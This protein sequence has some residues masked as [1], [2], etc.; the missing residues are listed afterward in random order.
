MFIFG[1][2]FSEMPLNQL[3]KSSS[4]QNQILLGESFA[5]LVGLFPG[6]E[7]HRSIT[8]WIVGILSGFKYFK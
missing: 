2:A 6:L 5:K 1:Q 7:C 4:S 8:S 3:S